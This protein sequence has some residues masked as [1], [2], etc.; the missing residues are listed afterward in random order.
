MP[1][2]R[3]RARRRGAMPAEL[4][5]IGRNG[6]IGGERVVSAALFV[7]QQKSENGDGPAWWSDV[8]SF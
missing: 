8:R 1:A 2:T 5:W 3:R 7:E 4:I 6:G